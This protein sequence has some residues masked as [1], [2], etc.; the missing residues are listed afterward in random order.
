MKVFL[1]EYGLVIAVIIVIAIIIIISRAM[2]QDGQKKI[3][4]TYSNFSSGA[5]AIVTQSLDESLNLDSGTTP[6]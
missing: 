6:P 1:E 2:A 3:I 5:D 4:A